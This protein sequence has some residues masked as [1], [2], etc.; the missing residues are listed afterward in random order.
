MRLALAWKTW[1]FEKRPE[2]KAKDQAGWPTGNY[3]GSK[4]S[5]GEHVIVKVPDMGQESLHLKDTL[6]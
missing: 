3:L 1:S 2:Y 6:A 5:P 4:G